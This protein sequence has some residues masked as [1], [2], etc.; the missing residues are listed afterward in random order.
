MQS[1]YSRYWSH[2]FELRSI[3]LYLFID[4]LFCFSVWSFASVFCCKTFWWNVACQMMHEIYKLFVFAS[5]SVT[6][7]LVLEF[8]KLSPLYFSFEF[9][10]SSQSNQA[11]EFYRLVSF[12]STFSTCKLDLLAVLRNFVT[13]ILVALFVIHSDDSL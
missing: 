10:C 8:W 12:R 6:L 9:N 2:W 13:H 11:A 3:S 1:T 5:M 4:S 7:A